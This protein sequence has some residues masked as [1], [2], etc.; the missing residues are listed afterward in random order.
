MPA[1][2]FMDL[3]DRRVRAPSVLFALGPKLEGRVQLL[4]GER[5]QGELPSKHW[6]KLPPCVDVDSDLPLLALFTFHLN[7]H[8]PAAPRQV[9]NLGDLLLALAE[10]AYLSRFAVHAHR[11]WRA[12]AQ[13]LVLPANVHGHSDQ[14]HNDDMAIHPS[15]GG[16]EA[17]RLVYS[18]QRPPRHVEACLPY[19]S[20]RPL[21]AERTGDTWSA[22]RSSVF[23]HRGAGFVLQLV[24]ACSQHMFHE[25]SRPRAVQPGFGRLGKPSGYVH[26]ETLVPSLPARLEAFIEARILVDISP[27][28]GVCQ[29]LE[30]L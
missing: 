13:H 1:V 6:L 24:I 8:R 11:V 29:V 25:V 23:S 19:G 18:R 16:T 3:M 28:V 10:D 17:R 20:R 22:S 27:S 5:P 4:R 15:D 30:D 26:G 2:A 7:T 21:V 12:H 14:A 9:R